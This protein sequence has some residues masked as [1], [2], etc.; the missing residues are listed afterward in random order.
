MST[1]K[2]LIQA[3]G[4]KYKSEPVKADKVEIKAEVV[5][6]GEN[7]IIDHWVVSSGSHVREN[8]IVAYVRKRSDNDNANDSVVAPPSKPKHKRPSRRKKSAKVV[9][10]ES[11]HS[12]SNESSL[13]AAA[14]SST[15]MSLQKLLASKT[16]PGT[17]INQTSDKAEVA[18][19]DETKAE[20]TTTSS[21]T[22]TI[23]KVKQTMPIHAPATGILRIHSNQDN[24]QQRKLVV[25]V[26]EKC[27]CPT[28]LDGMCVVCGAPKPKAKK[29]GGCCS[30]NCSP[31][32][33]PSSSSS[34]PNSSDDKTSQVTVS[35]G[36]TMRISQQESEKIALADTERLF[37]LKKLSL[38]LDLD[39]TLVH[40]TSDARARQYL[41]P[42]HPMGVPAGD[43][44]IISLPMFEGAQN[45]D[46]R[47]KFM[48]SQH[49][50]KLRPY[51]KEFLEGV[52]DTYEL[53]VYT[54]GTR[55]YAEE[56]AMVLCRKMAGSCMDSDE[57]ERLRQKV[58]LAER[59]LAQSQKEAN[60]NKNE[61]PQK[62]RKVSFQ[63]SEADTEETVKTLQA[64]LRS[65]VLLESKAR[66]LRQ[67]VFGSRIVS[68]TDVGD[69]GRDVKSLKRIFP[70]GGSMAAVVDDREDVWAN[71][72]DNS[73][74]TIKG[75]PPDNL[76][77]VRPYHW[78]PFVGFADINNAAGADLS[79]SGPAKSDEQLL[80]TKK[81][82]E[83]LHRRYYEQ[84]SEGKRKTVPEMLKQ[85]RREV[86]M[87]CNVVLS[88]LVPLHKQ[89]NTGAV[90]ARPH[91]IRYTQNLGAKVSSRSR[92]LYDCLLKNINSSTHL[93]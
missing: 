15:T 77:L 62:K 71:A 33:A 23:S 67:R 87:G 54:A 65:A 36:V 60:E 66:D 73:M 52:Q 34:T 47:H 30:G 48:R 12:T 42:S 45:P 14:K 16:N 27:Q 59:K 93:F 82:L 8:D 58:A 50:V 51:V 56:I 20:T 69:L 88:G 2:S 18:K 75:E 64:E 24:V 4:S 28:F 55:R 86:L 44:R 21:S 78:Q 9:V 29:S 79:G 39:H 3:I 63:V 84:S 70:C 68:R 90:V 22:T 25:G 85:M 1:T 91:F 53:S 5:I 7:V 38:V 40:A 81:I 19:T 72:K 43:L 31:S 17:T 80:W 83:N 32:C 74:G 10:K 37:G 41:D 76:L 92:F 6:P 57:L 13:P 11:N 46:P 61:P 35:G 49:F 26:I 89:S